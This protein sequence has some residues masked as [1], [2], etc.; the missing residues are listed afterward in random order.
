MV[1]S[2]SMTARLPKL[3]QTTD[4][5]LKIFGQASG[6]MFC[7]VCILSDASR[8]QMVSAHKDSLPTHDARTFVKLQILRVDR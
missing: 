5:G 1:N 2:T 6:A 7:N 3:Y 8:R 4:Q